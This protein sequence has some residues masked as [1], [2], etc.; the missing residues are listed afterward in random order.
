MLLRFCLYGFLKDQLY[1]ESF[2]LLAFLQRGLSFSE[3]G[4]LTGFLHLCVNLLEVPT[5]AIADVLGRRRSMIVSMLAYIASFVIFST[6]WRLWTWFVAMAFFAVGQ[7]FRTGTHKAIIFD[8]LNR[9]GRS[10]EK[11]HVY[12]LTRSWS[13]LGSAVCVIIAAVIV[14]YTEDYRAL[15]LYSLIPYV[16]NVLNFMTYS[17][18]LDGPRSGHGQVSSVAR[19]LLTA[20]VESFRRRRMRRLLIESMGFEGL[21][22]SAKDYIQ[23]II[24][25]AALAAP[26]LLTLDDRRRTAVLV[27]AVYFL[28]HVLSSAASRRSGTLSKRAGGDKRAARMLWL[29][30][31]LGFV[32]LAGGA[33]ANVPAVM[34]GAFVLLAVLQNFWRPILVSRFAS[35]SDPSRTATLLSIESQ[36]KSLFIAVIAPLLGWSVDMIAAATRGGPAFMASWRFLPIAAIG[37]AIPLGMLTI[38]RRNAVPAVSQLR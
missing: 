17:S 8:W 7:A 29:G 20:L 28:L 4:L 10:S 30:D 9:Q 27:G 38:S 34:I 32:I 24:K 25:A 26:V 15:F 5:G 2:F 18:Y 14:F 37:V 35:L 31:L 23:P 12:G 21:Y 13:K 11:T 3:W 33:I 6:A 36:A 1:F 16:L 19:T 22:N